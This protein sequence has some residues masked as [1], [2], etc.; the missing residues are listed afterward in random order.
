MR[1]N[2]SVFSEQLQTMNEP[3]LLDYVKSIFK[4]WKSFKAFLRAWA[5]RADTT[6]LVESSAV[7]EDSSLNVELLTFNVQPATVFPW[8][9]LL[10]LLLALIAQRTFE[11]PNQSAMIGMPL[12]L[13]AF[14][15]AL[16]AFLRGEWTP[17]SLPTSQTNADPLTVRGG[18]FILSLAAGTVAFIM[19]SDNKFT[20]WNVSVWALA[21]FLHIRAFWL[22]EPQSL[23]KKIAASFS[24]LEGNTHVLRW[25]LLV[26]AV[27]VLAIAFRF[28]RLADVPPEMT[29]DHAEKLMDVFD[30]RNGQYSIYFPR[31]TGRE[32]LYIYL[33]AF[34]AGFTGISFL[35]IKIAAVIGGLLM[36]P[37]LYL[38]GKELGS[39]RI[40]LLAV[41]FAAIAYWPGVIE[42][43][44]LRI[45]FYPLFVAPTL[46]YLI[47]G[48]RRQQRNDFILAGIALG[49]GL[50]GYM[51]FR[52][53]PFAVVAIVGI[54]LLHVRDKQVRK[55]ILL[56]LAL[57]ALTSWVIFIPLARY[58]TENPDMFGYRALTRLSSIE[59]PLPG[60]AWQLFLGNLWNAAKEF[61]WYNGNIWVH[62]IPDRPALDI[63]SGALFLL[64]VFL[65]LIRYLRSHHWADLVVLLA[66]P[67]TQMPSILSLAFPVENPSLNR[68]AGAIV[69]VFLL[70]GV[71]LDGLL[72][73]FGSG[74]K[75]AALAWS[76]AGI[77]FILSS[78]QNYDLIFHQ[79][80][81]QYRLGA[82]NT[83]EMGALMK[84][85]AEPDN[86]WIVP[87]PFW[88]DTRLP[89]IWAGL[90]GRDIAMARESL[91]TTLTVPGPKLFMV[92]INDVETLA[93]LQSLYPLGVLQRFE[94]AIDSRD[95][96]VYSVP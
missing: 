7:V 38:L 66:V 47:R 30:I 19:M 53:M 58:A 44:A 49:L 18:T 73:S 40:G 23:W 84:D 37:Y 36:L 12:Y 94:S 5:D 75:R 42:R 59:Q 21:I 29:S 32:P 78:I 61:N 28:Y 33:S 56:W 52:I 76:L 2:K 48:L 82:W 46:Y 57:L 80:N 15:L 81:E 43:F 14:G 25:A 45:S 91:P 86:V 90:P 83:S 4:D 85:F 96:W 88:A 31:N 87:Y 54:Y 92:A 17:A 67:M 8:R 24:R 16:W 68:T 89:P 3:T 1:V 41:A 10:A 9:S 35:T 22:K 79:Y 95:F 50:Y 65:V 77:L 6:Q 13:A 55:Q 74:K 51:P 39:A 70:V 64:G 11:P 72:T 62:S 26:A 20:G 69:P 60:P 71:G 34:I 63:V 93:V 27:F